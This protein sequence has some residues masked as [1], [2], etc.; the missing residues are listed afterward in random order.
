VPLSHFLILF[1]AVALARAARPRGARLCSADLV[2]GPSADTV[3][4]LISDQRILSG[5]I[6]R[7]FRFPLRRAFPGLAG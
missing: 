7:L 1:N 3:Q 6:Q 5:K 2:I 4:H